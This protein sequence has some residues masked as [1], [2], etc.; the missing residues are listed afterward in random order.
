[1]FVSQEFYELRRRGPLKTSV[2]RKTARSDDI[3]HCGVERQGSGRKFSSG[4]GGGLGLKDKQV[5]MSQLGGGGRVRGYAPPEI[6][7]FNSS[8]MPRNAFKINQRNPKIQ[9]F[10]T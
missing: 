5:K 7:Y 10:G 4:G 9:T 1:M 2:S 6:F 3:L 8:Q